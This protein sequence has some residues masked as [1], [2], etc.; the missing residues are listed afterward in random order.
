[1]NGYAQPIAPAGEPRQQYGR[2]YW[3]IPGSLPLQRR[4]ELYAKAAET[5]TTAG[6]SYDDAGIG[7]LMDKTAVLWDIPSNEWAKY[8]DWF[9]Q[10]YPGTKVEF[11][12]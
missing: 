9:N 3:V 4:K 5:N 2:F 7:S 12:S 6:P 11:R 1:M 10:N 8:I